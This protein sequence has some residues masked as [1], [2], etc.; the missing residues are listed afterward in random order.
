MIRYLSYSH[1]LRIMTIALGLVIGTG[2]AQG[3]TLSFNRQFTGPGIDRATAVAADE[4][5]I[6][7][8]GAQT[9]RAR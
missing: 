8:A 6:Y 5:G 4:S 3:Q 2:P 1:N 7:V 9:V